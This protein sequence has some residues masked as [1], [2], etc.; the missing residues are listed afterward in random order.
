[1]KY[2][3]IDI[4][5]TGLDPEND[6]ILEIAMI[7]EDTNLKQSLDQLPKLHIYVLRDTYKGGSKAIEMNAHTFKRI[8]ELIEDDCNTE[9]ILC[10]EE[11]IDENVVEFFIDNKINKFSKISIAGANLE[12]FDMKFL[13]KVLQ[14]DVIDSF[15]RRAIE[16]AHFFVDWEKDKKLPTLQECKKRAG[17]EGDVAHNA[18]DDAWDVIQVLRTQY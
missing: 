13:K 11:H 4:E 9:S 12:G 16:P 14:E 7:L 18:L 5:T 3:S 1:M 8:N 17:I 6:Q 10:R 15:N 2:L